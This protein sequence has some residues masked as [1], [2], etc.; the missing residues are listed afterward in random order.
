MAFHRYSDEDEF[1]D[2]IKFIKVDIDVLKDVVEQLGVRALPTFISF[3]DGQ[4]VNELVGANPD[5]L[6]SLLRQINA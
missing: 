3:K 6:L 2:N 5:L 4:K 1:K